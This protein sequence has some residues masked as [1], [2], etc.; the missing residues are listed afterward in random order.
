LIQ[1]STFGQKAWLIAPPVRRARI[2]IVS[3]TQMTKPLKISRICPPLNVPD[4]L[5]QLSK[6]EVAD[7]NRVARPALWRPH[8]GKKRGF[9]VVAILSLAIGIGAIS[10]IFSVTNALL[11]R[12]LP[13]KDADRLVIMWNRSLG[14]N[15][16][17]DWFSPGQYL[18]IKAENH[19]FEQV[20][21]TL[22]GSYN[23]TGHGTPEHVD[24]ARV[25]S[26][27][28]PLFFERQI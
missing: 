16:V 19:V 9:T 22:G 25:S 11:L 13:Y 1:A 12:P 23:F 6:Q 28:F 3:G 18:D 4:R 21:T 7:G 15:V 17:Q 10:A 27:L 8:P 20:T 24:G 26:S 14:L 2:A 5:T